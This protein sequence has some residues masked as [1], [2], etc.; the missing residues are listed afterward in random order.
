MEIEVL[1]DQ[2]NEMEIRII[3]EDDTFANLLRKMLH[4]DDH[5]QTAAYRITHPLTERNKPIFK[6]V[7]DG[8]ESPAEAL[9]KA[10]TKTKKIFGT[11][12]KKLT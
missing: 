3:G 4:E 1:N 9:K 7:T 2:K 5:V 6:I 11:L 10:A 12:R 8:K